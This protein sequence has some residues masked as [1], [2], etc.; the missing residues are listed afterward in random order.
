[1]TQDVKDI[2]LAL[3]VLDLVL[4]KLQELKPKRPHTLFKPFPFTMMPYDGEC[5]GAWQRCM[6]SIQSLKEKAQPQ[7]K[8]N[9]ISASQIYQAIAASINT[10]YASLS[11]TSKIENSLE[12]KSR[13]VNI[14]F[15]KNECAAQVNEI[16]SRSCR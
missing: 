14:E 13:K 9:D 10:Y 8:V 4:T 15:L 7:G 2:Q 5:H 6:D 16:S 1:M 3:S 11:D 12:F